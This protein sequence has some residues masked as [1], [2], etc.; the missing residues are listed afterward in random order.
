MLR[1]VRIYCL[2]TAH[3]GSASCPAFPGAG[4]APDMLS[5]SFKFIFQNVSC[6]APTGFPPFPGAA[7]E[8]EMLTSLIYFLVR[9]A[10]IP[11]RLPSLPFREP[12]KTCYKFLV[13]VLLKAAHVQFRLLPLPFPE[14]GPEPP[15]KRKAA[16]SRQ[17][18]PGATRSHPGEPLKRSS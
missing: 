11:V 6:S 9:T 12:N 15:Q 1:F 5:F 14:A 7:P 18:P 4:P 17:A 8:P 16:R 10:H 13:H 3:S 2:K